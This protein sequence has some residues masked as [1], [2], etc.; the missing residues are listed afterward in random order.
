MKPLKASLLSPIG[1]TFPSF[2]VTSGFGLENRGL[3]S[4]SGRTLYLWASGPQLLHTSSGLA[5]N[6]PSL[7]PGLFLLLGLG[8]RT[9]N[10]LS[11]CNDVVCW[12]HVIISG[13]ND[14]KIRFWD[15]R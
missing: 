12:D 13:H 2:L 8:S 15:S 10:V 9:I 11:Y 6:N 5:H 3:G 14:Q 4:S 7:S 1:D